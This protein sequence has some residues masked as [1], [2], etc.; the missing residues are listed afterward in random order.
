MADWTQI[1]ENLRKH[2]H[3]AGRTVA[4]QDAYFEFFAGP[5]VGSLS[6]WVARL[7]KAIRQLKPGWS[8]GGL[9]TGSAGLTSA[10]AANG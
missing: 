8:S 2:G 9:H 7:T 6:R 3:F 4:E 10:K 5:D 1:D